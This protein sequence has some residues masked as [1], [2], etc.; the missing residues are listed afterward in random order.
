MR[1]PRNFYFLG[2]RGSA[3]SQTRM[4]VSSC[5]PLPTRLLGFSRLTL[6][7]CLTTRIYL[8]VTHAHPCA[9]VLY[10]WYSGLPQIFNLWEEEEV[11]QAKLALRVSSC[12][13]LPTKCACYSK[14]YQPNFLYISKK[15]CIFA[16]VNQYIHFFTNNGYLYPK[17]YHI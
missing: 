11:R 15:C 12:K 1:G 10:L 6:L 8:K 3:A 17:L 4:R 13:P 2:R 5:K 7:D 9:R 16:V 14:Q